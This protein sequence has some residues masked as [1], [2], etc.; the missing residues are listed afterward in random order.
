MQGN[1]GLKARMA[2][3][4]NIFELDD[5][6]Y[7]IPLSDTREVFR[8]PTISPLPKAPAVIEGIVNIRGRIV[9]VFDLRRRFGLAEKAPH[10][11]E[12][13]LL[14]AAGSRAVAMRVDRVL[15]A[16]DIAA[17]NIDAPYQTSQ[18]ASPFTGVAKLEDGLVLIHDLAAFLQESEE[19][20]LDQALAAAA[21]R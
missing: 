9:P 3:S 7:G 14:A 21:R 18:G 10:P 4:I 12:H 19:A 8:L 1:P 16:A 5:G 6:R 15:G 2:T 11:A 20:E 17:E 13:L